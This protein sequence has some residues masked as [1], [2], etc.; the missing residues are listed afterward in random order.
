MIKAEECLRL[1]EERINNYLD[2]SSTT[3]LLRYVEEQ[4]L[5]QHKGPLLDKEHSGCRALLRDDKVE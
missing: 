4:L 3:K 2:Q 5:A 1:E